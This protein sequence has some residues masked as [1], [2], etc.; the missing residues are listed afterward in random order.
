MRFKQGGNQ[1]VPFIPF[2]FYGMFFGEV[3][4]APRGYYCIYRFV[5]SIKENCRQNIDITSKRY[6]H[7]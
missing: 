1:F 6:G 2:V 3:L 4:P 5:S 7:K